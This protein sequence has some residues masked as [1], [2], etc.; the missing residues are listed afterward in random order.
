MPF[1]LSTSTDDAQY[2]SA[3]RALALLNANIETDRQY[4]LE[5]HGI[6]EANPHGLNPQ[7]VADGFFSKSP[8]IPV[9]A[10]VGLTVKT[11]A[12]TGSLLPAYWPKREW[13]HDAST[14]CAV[15]TQ[16]PWSP[17]PLA[18]GGIYP[19][20]AEAI[21]ASQAM[22]AV[23]RAANANAVSPVAFIGAL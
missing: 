23:W 2:L 13:L 18:T 17:A 5:M 16:V 9:F 12:V 14:G 6:L 7:Q 8:G 20:L 10:H 1:T 3:V 15:A 4:M 22:L 19:T 21:A 11:L